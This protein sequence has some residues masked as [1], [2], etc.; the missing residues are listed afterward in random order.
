MGEAQGVREPK[1]PNQFGLW[2][3]FEVYMQTGRGGSPRQ[4]RH[5]IRASKVQ[6]RQLHASMSMQSR[7]LTWSMSP[8]S[9]WSPAPPAAPPPPHPQSHTTHARPHDKACMHSKWLHGACNM[10]HT[11][12]SQTR[13]TL[14]L[15]PQALGQCN[16]ALLV[17]ILSQSHPTHTPPSSLTFCDGV[18]VLPIIPLAPGARMPTTPLAAV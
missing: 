15:E 5:N 1:D 3:K 9:P 11:P 6:I 13:A 7:A 12:P 10:H 2:G 4:P 14:N 8:S 16:P 18:H 17:I